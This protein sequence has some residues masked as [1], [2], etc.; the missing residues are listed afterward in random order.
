MIICSLL[1]TGKCLC[2]CLCQNHVTERFTFPS[3]AS[4]QDLWPFMPWPQLL[5]AQGE[6]PVPKLCLSAEL[7]SGCLTL[8]GLRHLYSPNLFCHF[9][10]ENAPLPDLCF[11]GLHMFCILLCLVHFWCLQDHPLQKLRKQRQW[12]CCQ[13]IQLSL[14]ALYKQGKSPS[15]PVSYMENG[16]WVQWGDTQDNSGSD[17]CASR[18]FFLPEPAVLATAHLWAFLPALT[19]PAFQLDTQLYW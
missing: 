3:L 7:A 17:P 9:D 12:W 4:Q 19:Q 14:S 1:P 2:F 5:S 8:S 15:E 11:S 16:D 6:H 18:V 13:K 10:H